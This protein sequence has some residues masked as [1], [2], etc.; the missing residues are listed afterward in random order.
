[1]LYGIGGVAK[2][3]ASLVMLPIYTFY[4]SPA[5]YGAIE[6]ITLIV[7][8]LSLIAG[9]NLGEGLFRFYHE[10]E[11]RGG[12]RHT[13]ASALGLALGLNTLGA[14]LLID[15]SPLLAERFLGADY[16]WTYI[17]LASATLVT[18]ASVSIVSCHM[19]AEG[20]AL[21]YFLTGM[22]RLALQV[23]LNLFFLAGLELGVKGV[24][25]AGLAATF[26]VAVVV[27]PYTL[28]R[29]GW[30]FSPTSAKHLLAFGGPLVV[31]NAATFYL[32]ASDR[33]FLENYQGLAAVGVYAL[34]AR[35][36]SGF[37]VLIYD[38]FEQVWDPEKYRIWRASRDIKAFQRVFR[39]LALVLV[40]AGS[41]VSVFAPE[42]FGLLTSQAFAEAAN[43]APILIAASV[44]LGLGRFARFGSL[45]AGKTANVYKS[46][47]ASALV[48]TVL[49]W[50]CV[51]RFGAYG[52]AFAAAAANGFR[53]ALDD[54]LARKQ[55]N[56][57]LPWIRFAWLAAFAACV[58][59]G[60]TTLPAL[61]VIGIGAK[62]LVLAVFATIAWYSPLLLPD[63]RRFALRLVGLRRFA[64]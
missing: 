47:L 33:F 42:I 6:I 50:L 39:L 45:I 41:T 12:G 9:M 27:L 37:G 43:V 38:P 29:V 28:R 26:L 58:V 62:L 2:H 24:L 4:L 1:M 51:P 60:C 10:P 44:F 3:L 35:L 56:L 55:V 20:D 54:V 13:V 30:A 46:A 57:H 5:D 17:A 16:P 18:E 22:L 40:I 53:M 32:G 21:K 7:S 64:T 61:T 8:S 19:R 23:G 11:E 15:C 14:L 49:L 34:A 52:A 36:A 48:L 31:A 25:I 63:D 59:W